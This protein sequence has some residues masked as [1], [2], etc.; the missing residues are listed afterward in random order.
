MLQKFQE[1]TLENGLR[2][3]F[4]IPNHHFQMDSRSLL[5]L[6]LKYLP[7]FINDFFKSTG[8]SW[9]EVNWTVPHQASKTGLNM[10]P[11]IAM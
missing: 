5:R 11:K 3:I 10:I 8:I 2:I 4:T 9:P 7:D 1:D 6:T